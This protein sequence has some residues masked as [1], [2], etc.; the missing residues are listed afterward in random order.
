MTI[1]L[2][3]AKILII[4]KLKNEK[5]RSRD[6]DRSTVNWLVSLGGRG[7][8]KDVSS[9]KRKITTETIKSIKELEGSS[10][11]LANFNMLS[12]LIEK[13]RQ[14]ALIIKGP[15]LTPGEHDAAMLK[16]KSLLDVLYQKFKSSEL[17]DSKMA[18]RSHFLLM[19]AEDEK[20]Y[21]AEELQAISESHKSM[22]ILIR[23]KDRVSIFGFAGIF[24]EIS[25]DSDIFECLPCNKQMILDSNT[26]GEEMY[27]EILAKTGVPYKD[28]FE[29]YDCYICKYITKRVEIQ[30]Y[31]DESIVGTITKGVSTMVG[32]PELTA[33]K[34]LLALQYLRDCKIT[35]SR[36]EVDHPGYQEE[37]KKQVLASLIALKQANVELCAEYS[38]TP[39]VP[40]TFNVVTTVSL[41]TELTPDTGYLEDY[42]VLAINDIKK[43]DECVEESSYGMAM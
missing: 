37:R 17:L 5:K 6:A 29:I 42:I 23:G 14:D 30:L 22:P 43:M 19:P 18:T 31:P 8:N 39:Q 20:E 12:E 36:L 3:L 2:Y 11:D 25:L 10:N 13:C 41:G 24:K 26:L 34:E 38:V 7:R 27:Q 28:P 40:L 15:K 21:E 1:F 16:I 35:L 9:N 4:K 33:K 32:T